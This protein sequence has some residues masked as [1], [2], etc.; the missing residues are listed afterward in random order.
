MQRG[1]EGSNRQTGTFL[2]RLTTASSIPV[3]L[4]GPS[5][6]TGQLPPQP[7]PADAAAWA[8]T[9]CNVVGPSTSTPT[10]G[11]LPQPYQPH[12]YRNPTANGPHTN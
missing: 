11:R 10:A 9:G 4:H 5:R 8:T 7:R 3:T 12:R 1:H 2:A 6:A